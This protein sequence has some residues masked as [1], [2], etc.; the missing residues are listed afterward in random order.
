MEGLLLEAVA[1]EQVADR[2]R[3][4]AAARLARAAR[5]RGAGRRPAARILS[6]TLTFW[7]PRA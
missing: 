5:R 2:A 4:A 1:R 6:G 7:H 3:R